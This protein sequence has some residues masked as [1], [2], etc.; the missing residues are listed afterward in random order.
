MQDLYTVGQGVDV[1]KL[2]VGTMTQTIQHS[3]LHDA[4][5]IHVFIHDPA[6]TSNGSSAPL[7][8]SGGREV[9]SADSTSDKAFK[10]L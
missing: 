5:L 9:C 10:A 3:R 7:L 8:H 6:L 4:F 1:N 2:R